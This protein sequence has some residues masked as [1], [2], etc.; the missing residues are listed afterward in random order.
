MPLLLCHAG[1]H[2]AQE[3]FNDD[4]KRKAALERGLALVSESGIQGIEVVTQA[5]IFCTLSVRG[6]EMAL[7]ALKGQLQDAGIDAEFD[8]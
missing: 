7:T 4:T 8:W 1:N 5:E 3:D 2:L 6:T